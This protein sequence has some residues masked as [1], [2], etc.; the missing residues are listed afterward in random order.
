MTIR[1]LRAADVPLAR[2]L[3]AMFAA[4]FAEP[5]TYLSEPPPDQYLAEL[6]GQER[7]LVLAALCE[8]AVVGGLVA[9]ELD[10][11]DRARRELYIYDLAVAEAHR[12]RGVATTLILRA[13]E[14]AAERGAWVMY[15]QADRGDAPAVALYDQLGQR[16]EV[17]HFDIA[18][19]PERR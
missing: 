1:R 12:R 9:Y 3:N 2:K 17:L 15:I 14:I 7:I 19:E 8:E 4:A 6:L 13:R 16:E 10:K 5:E 18:V 11:L